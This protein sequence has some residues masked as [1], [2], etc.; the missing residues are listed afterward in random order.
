[1]LKSDAQYPCTASDQPWRDPEGGFSLI[2]LSLVIVI[3]GILTAIALPVLFSVNFQAERAR[4]EAATANS[5][6]I[7]HVGH[8]SERGLSQIEVDLTAF[9]SRTAAD[10]SSAISLDD[11]ESFCVELTQVGIGTARSGPGCT[12]PAWSDE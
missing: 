3:V 9:I 10:A 7:V 12:K 11:R 5:A 6:Q 2:E 8:A 1:M 4:L